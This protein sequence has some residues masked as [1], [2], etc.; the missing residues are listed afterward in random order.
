MSEL[1]DTGETKQECYAR[2][3]RVLNRDFDDK[4]KS[5][6]MFTSKQSIEDERE[7]A[8]KKLHDCYYGGRGYGGFVE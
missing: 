8:L 4:I 2:E 6:S 1:H 3:K 7:H 5:K